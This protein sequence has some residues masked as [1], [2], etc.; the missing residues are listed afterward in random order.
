MAKTKNQSVVTQSIL[1]RLITSE[2]DEWTAS[3]AQSL[4]IFR[5][6][7][8]RDVEWLLN[9][10]RP[11]LENLAKYPLASNSVINYGLPDISSMGLHSAADQRTLIAA[12]QQCLRNYEPRITQVCVILESSEVVN[13][14]LRFR[15]EGMMMI[16]P[17]PEEINFDTVLELTKGEYEVK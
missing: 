3:R 6:A 16:D 4:R 13:R 7:L 8:K 1:D 10:R 15:I 9:S 17:A 2:T 14:S 11:P 5:D 12:V